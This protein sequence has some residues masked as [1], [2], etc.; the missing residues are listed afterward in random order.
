[1]IVD[2][3]IIVIIVG[4]ILLG[5][6]QGWIKSFMGLLGWTASFLITFFLAGVVAGALVQVEGIA[7]FLYSEAIFGNLVEVIPQFLTETEGIAGLLLFPFMQYLESSYA[8]TSGAVSMHNATIAVLVFAIFTSVIAFI[9]FAIVRTILAI[10]SHIIRKVSKALSSRETPSIVSRLIG[11]AVGGVRGLIF[12]LSAF[13]F[14]GF[15]FPILEPLIDNVD[16]SMMAR[17]MLVI[18]SNRI[19]SRIVGSGGFVGADLEI[20]IDSILSHDI[21]QDGYKDGTLE[22]SDSETSNRSIENDSFENEIE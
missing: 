13:I 22:G 16:S 4:G 2:I 18:S 1:M 6:W 9:M 15:F 7:N 8:V 11:G 21:V 20:V 12:V 10:V 5:L 14:F 3:I 17:P 19:T